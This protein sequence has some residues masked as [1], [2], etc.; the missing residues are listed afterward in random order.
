[1][2]DKKMLLTQLNNAVNLR[3][4]H[5]QI[6]W[7]VFAIFWPT[8][9]LLLTIITKNRIL[10]I[11]VPFIGIVMSII[12]YLTQQRTIKHLLRYDDFI[13][14]IEENLEI[15]NSFAISY[16]INLEDYDRYISH[17]YVAP[18]IMNFAI[19]LST[20]FWIVLFLY[21]LSKIILNI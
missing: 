19:I 3:S 11:I 13:R 17:G 8:N 2:K 7:T 4:N 21:Y 16:R 12:W 6:F 15:D 14:R 18:Q 1:M 9:I 20:V 10:D 5:N